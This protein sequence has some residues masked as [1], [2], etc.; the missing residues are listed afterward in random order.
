MKTSIRDR[1]STSGE[2]LPGKRP[3]LSRLSFV[4]VVGLVGIVGFAYPGTVF[5]GEADPRPTITILVNNYTQVSSAV[6]AEAEREAG[7]ILHESGL[8]VLWLECPAVQSSAHTQGPCQKAPEATDIRLRILSAPVLDKFHN[9]VF[10]FAVHPVLASVYYEYVVRLAKSDDAVFEL[11]IILGCAIAHEIGHLLLGS[12]SHWAIGIM[13]RQ[14][15]SEQLRQAMMGV[16]VFTSE[17][18]KILREEAKRRTLAT[19]AA[20]P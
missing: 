7:R 5:A 14:W 8:Q 13:Q 19:R 12:N 6:L 18:S 20:L 4:V 11:P 10:G 15:R 3:L 17:Q 9:S 2:A 16:L 1:H